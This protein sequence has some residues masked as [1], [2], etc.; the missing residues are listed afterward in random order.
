MVHYVPPALQRID[1]LVLDPNQIAQLPLYRLHK[2][3]P[4]SLRLEM[5]AE[6]EAFLADTGMPHTRFALAISGRPGF[7]T[8]LRRG[9]SPSIRLADR[10]LAWIACERAAAISTSR[11]GTAEVATKSLNVQG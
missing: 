10:M 1:A 4:L 11:P 6:M 5:L 3:Q 2:A 8:E 9:H 7:I